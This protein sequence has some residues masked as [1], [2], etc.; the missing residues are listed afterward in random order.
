MLQKLKFSKK[1]PIAAAHGSRS[2]HTVVACSATWVP[3]CRLAPTAMRH[4]SMCP[5][6]WATAHAAV[7]RGSRIPDA[8]GHDSRCIVLQNFGWTIYFCKIEIKIYKKIL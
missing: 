8:M 7:Q 5:C 6:Q 1:N 4:D 2:I 3:R